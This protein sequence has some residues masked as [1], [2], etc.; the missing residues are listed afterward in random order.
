MKAYIFEMEYSVSPGGK[1][2]WELE[3]GNGT[4]CSTNYGEFKSAGKALDYLITKYPDE[5]LNVDIVSLKAYNKSMGEI[6]V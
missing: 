4:A 2:C 3:V 1:D 6:N 5:E